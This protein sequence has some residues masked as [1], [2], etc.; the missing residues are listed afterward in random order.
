MLE[1]R[2]SLFQTCYF[3]FHFK[4]YLSFA[5][6]EAAHCVQYSFFIMSKNPIPYRTNS[7][8][9]NIDHSNRINGGKHQNYLQ[10]SLG[11]EISSNN[12]A[13]SL[14]IGNSP[15]MQ[16]L[17]SIINRV[18]QIN[19]SVL[20]NGATGTG[21]EIVARAIHLSSSRRHAPFVDIN[22]SAIPETLFEAEVFGH[23]RGTFTGAHETRR[24]LFEEA[25][26]G[27]IFLDE[28]D[29]LN[30]SAQAKLLRVLQE[31]QLR[32]VGGRENIPI[33]V[34]IISATN[35]DLH[36]AVAEGSFRPDLFFRLRVVPLQVPELRKHSEDIELLVNHFLR[37]AA[38]RSGHKTHQHYF[39]QEALCTLTSYTWPGNVRELENAVEY[40]L[41]IG[42]NEELGINDLPPDVIQNQSQ[43][44]DIIHQCLSKNAPLAEVERQYI[45]QMFEQFH[46]QRSKTAAALGIDRR[47]LYRRLKDYGLINDDDEGD[48]LGN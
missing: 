47:T 19:S 41:A 7:R 34:R 2:D 45:I 11:H 5:S 21:K 40:A 27:T 38:M 10:V 32:R 14:L 48:E 15:A 13:S 23:Q 4:S 29:A 22:C 1:A 12:I 33:D 31:R 8:P 9:L 24:G 18:A 17:L 46:R 16:Q 35:K 42:T 25:S 37:Q 36:A 44:N 6:Q 30:L 39:S 43:A 20:I 26:G 28:V 3:P